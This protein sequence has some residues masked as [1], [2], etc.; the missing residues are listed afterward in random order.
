MSDALATEPSISHEDL[1]S[2][3]PAAHDEHSS[4]GLVSPRAGRRG[5]R[6]FADV[7]REL[8]FLSP[9]RVEA[10]TAEAKAS[11]HRLEDVLLGTGALT[12]DQVARVMAERLGLPYV[13][14]TVYEADLAATNLLGVDAAKRYGAVPI[15]YADGG[16]LLVAMADPSNVIA[17]DD[18]KLTLGRDRELQMA[19][20]S[21]DDIAGLIG[22]MDRLDEA[23]AQAVEAGEEESASAQPV[24]EIKES[25]EDAPVIR[26]VNSIV[27]QALTDGASDI[28][29]EPQGRDMRVRFRV[30]G[31]LAERTT[32]PRSMVAG[33][34]SRVKIM[35]NLDISERRLPQDGRVG[36]TVERRPIDIRVVTM[37]GVLGEGLVM[38]L[39]DK[40]SVLIT[41]DKLGMPVDGRERFEQAFRASYGAVLVTGP[42]GS[43][44]S[45]TLYAALNQLNSIE[46][47]II[48]IEDPVEYQLPGVNQLQ[49]SPKG[50]L[51]FP[52]ALRSMLRADPDIIMVGEIRD[53]ETARIGIES[54]LT[55][56][57]VLSTLHT[58]DAPS[59]LPRFT[60][61]GV[62]PFL[63]ASAVGC[64]VAQRLARRLCSNCKR[65]T[66]L[67]KEVL[68]AAG[69]N[70]EQSG[71]DGLPAH[72]PGGCGRCKFSGYKG[73]LGLYEV[74]KVTEDIRGMTVDRASAS[75]IRVVAQQQGMRPLREDGLGKVLAGLT[76]LEEVTRVT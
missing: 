9:G 33:V 53:S 50:G 61:M 25:A 60:D 44:K 35:A 8:G 10:A 4:G 64:V 59:A 68:A 42:T 41:L 67:T 27:A 51:T 17:F 31:V 1:H 28:H 57:L 58:N 71:A 37:P 73:R 56:H 19:V 22:R 47:N 34:V 13:D 36:I 48:T 43:G 3:A 24:V 5:S 38:R 49:V 11:G 69:L 26:L 15:G 14:L 6:T 32:I 39:L 2:P 30:D 74:M 54:A 23:V 62:E 75:A 18:L 63:T 70:P 29:F 76:S 55:G 45:T 16:R 21:K 72:E 46:K 20:A 52:S 66:T 40:E 7:V 65:P 12:P